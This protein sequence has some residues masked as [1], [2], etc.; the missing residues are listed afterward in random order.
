M[1]QHLKKNKK[2]I[3]NVLIDI[4]IINGIIKENRQKSTILRQLTIWVCFKSTFCHWTKIRP[5]WKSK[6]TIKISLPIIDS[7]VIW[8]AMN[9]LMRLGVPNPIIND[10]DFKPA[11]FDRQFRSDSDFSNEMV[12]TIV[13]LIYFWSNFDYNQSISI[14]FQ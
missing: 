8:C 2:N 1:S 12:L 4:V 13:I 7:K 10:S 5:H 9:K 11:N 14:C 6:V 3:V